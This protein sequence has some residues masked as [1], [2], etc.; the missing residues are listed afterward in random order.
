MRASLIEMLVIE[1]GKASTFNHTCPYLPGP[2]IVKDYILDS[3]KF[4]KIVPEGQYRL[5]IKLLEPKLNETFILVE[6]YL[7]VKPIGATVLAMG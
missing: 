6:I 2:Q 5:D 1:I 7:T 4:P 3:S